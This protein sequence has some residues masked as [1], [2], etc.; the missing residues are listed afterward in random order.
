LQID[1]ASPY[2]A[3]LKVE[4]GIINAHWEKAK[5]PKGIRDLL[6]R[7]KKKPLEPPKKWYGGTSAGT[8]APPESIAPENCIGLGPQ[9]THS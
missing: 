9:A 5:W 6:E 2:W 8:S 4:F 1:E 3:Y 7:A